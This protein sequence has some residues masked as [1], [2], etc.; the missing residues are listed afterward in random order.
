[1]LLFQI[2][3]R[4]DRVLRAKARASQESEKYPGQINC[5]VLMKPLVVVSFDTSLLTKTHLK[6]SDVFCFCNS[7]LNDDNRYVFYYYY[8]F[9]CGGRGVLN[10]KI[11]DL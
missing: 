4:R 1:M 10:Y 3:L 2:G 9:I 7:F 8:Y 5:F 11:S 6:N